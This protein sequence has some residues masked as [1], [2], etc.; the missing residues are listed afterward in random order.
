MLQEISARSSDARCWPSVPGGGGKG[1]S[2]GPGG[3]DA[4]RSRQAARRAARNTSEVYENSSRSI[5]RSG[6]LGP[7]RSRLHHAHD[8]SSHTCFRS[9][10]AFNCS[11][12]S[13]RLCYARPLGPQRY[14]PHTAGD[15]GDVDVADGELRFFL[16]NLRIFA[17]RADRELSNEPLAVEIAR[18]DFEN[19]VRYE[20]GYLFGGSQ[21]SWAGA[22]APA[23]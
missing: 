23:R 1:R 20:F 9:H 6:S 16:R 3:G 10:T 13:H 11:L 8:S 4:G 5:G 7:Q 22:R 21:S 12:P 14:R 15:A 2:P 18:L 17:S 19:R